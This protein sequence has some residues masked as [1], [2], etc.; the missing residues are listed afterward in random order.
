MSASSLG[1]ADAVAAAR[2][3]RT[4]KHPGRVAIVVNNDRFF[5]THRASWAVALRAAGAEVYVI[6]ADTGY[7]SNVKALGM[8]FL[9]LDFG[10]E[11]IRPLDAVIVSVKLFVLLLKIRPRLVYLIATAAYS[12]GWLAAVPLPSVRFIRVITGA[13]RAL[14]ASSSRPA[15]ARVVGLLLKTSARL[16]NVSSVFQI[17]SDLKQFVAT[18]MAEKRRSIVIGGTGIDTGAWSRQKDT[19]RSAPVT[20]LFAA[21]LFREKG[22]FSFVEVARRLHRTDTRFVVVGAPDSGVSS[23]VTENELSSWVDEGIIEYWGER[24]DMISVYNQADVFVFP[25]MH[26]EG[27]PKVLIEASACG[28][29]I[30]ASD[31]PGCRSVVEHGVSGL[32]V[33]A[34]DD[35]ALT[36]EVRRLIED[37]RLRA[38]LASAARISTVQTYSLET[39]L[40]RLFE[41][42][43]IKKAS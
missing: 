25:S 5:L 1:Q 9:P 22:I 14:D 6:A 17:E 2:L 23:S 34:G 38:N 10:R 30:V 32:I 29:A 15:G 39:V 12:L 24:D 42:S 31:Q 28:L 41:F 19:S 16:S 35:E 21:R 7:A 4:W 26:P 37:E 40:T 20:V 3:G 11:S 36:G 18:G 13:G 43:G 27:T 8:K 33:A